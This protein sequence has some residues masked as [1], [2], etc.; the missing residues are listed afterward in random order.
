MDNKTKQKKAKL[1]IKV[2]NANNSSMAQNLDELKKLGKEMDNA[3]T[4]TELVKEGN[5][6]PDPKQS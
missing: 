6:I 4:E 3:K 2:K 1:Q 5:L